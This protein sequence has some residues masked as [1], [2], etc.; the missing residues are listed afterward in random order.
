M[1]R[2]LFNKQLEL[3]QR[4]GL[5]PWSVDLEVI[6]LEIIIEFLSWPRQAC[7]KR[8]VLMAKSRGRQSLRAQEE[9]V[10]LLK[11]IKVESVTMK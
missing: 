2:S 7:F 10:K 1:Q 4:R 3:S 5:A 6:C 9:A 8:N 11:Y